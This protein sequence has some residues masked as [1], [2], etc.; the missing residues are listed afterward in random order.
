[1]FYNFLENIGLFIRIFFQYVKYKINIIDFNTMIKIICNDLS[2]TNIFYLKCFQWGIQD[3][4][5][6]DEELKCY[7]NNFYDNVPYSYDDID[8]SVLDRIPKLVNNE[9]KFDNNNYKPI[10][11]GTV[12]LVFKG[13]L[14][15]KPVAIKMLRKDIKQKIKSGINNIINLVNIFVYILS[16]FYEIK[17]DIIDLIKNNEQLLLEQ[18][19]FENE[20][21]NLE[22]FK[23]CMKNNTHIIIPDVYKEFK[24]LSDDIIVMDFLE[25]KIMNKIP[26]NQLKK[27]NHLL[28]S[29]IFESI[30]SHKLIHADLHLGNILILND[31]RIGIIDFGLV[32]KNSKEF[33]DN[34]F[35][36][37]LG[38]KNSNNKLII[39]K[40]IQAIIINKEDIPYVRDHLN[41]HCD[42][43]CKS[44]ENVSTKEMLQIIKII[45]SINVKINPMLCNNLL[46]ILS[47]LT[48]VEKIGENKPLKELFN[49]FVNGSNLRC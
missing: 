19:D 27:Y 42:L 22:L 35:Y 14:Y 13:M 29:F 20:I 24:I 6:I 7:F 16:F 39:N 28:R 30:L 32:I 37:L 43:I 8:Y 17:I 15:N 49:E 47:S 41:E 36:I 31:D 25:G 23:E 11:S 40:L 18:C 34:V 44:L 12:A 21:K 38:L 3:I 46:S 1:M 45:Q 26:I 33:T 9:F 2:N 5:S 48:M 10:N 4:Y